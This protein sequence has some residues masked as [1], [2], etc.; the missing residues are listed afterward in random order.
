MTRRPTS[1]SFLSLDKHEIHRSSSTMSFASPTQELL[2]R[3]DRLH[4]MLL[5]D[6]PNLPSDVYVNAMP[7]RTSDSLPRLAMTHPT[8]KLRSA[9][10]MTKSDSMIIDELQ[11]SIHQLERERQILLRSYSIILHLLK[12]KESHSIDDRGDL[13]EFDD[14]D[15][16]IQ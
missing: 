6:L 15:I 7:Q 14:S 2:D 10:M 3:I 1:S 16:F 11:Q 9:T 8:T 13:I 5:S 12:Q 4:S